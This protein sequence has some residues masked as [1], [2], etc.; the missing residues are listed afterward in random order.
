MPACTTQVED[1]NAYVY[2]GQIH[3]PNQ[4][5]AGITGS[6]MLVTLRD[7]GKIIGT[8][9]PSCD[10]VFVPAR[11]VCHECFEQIKKFVPVSSMGTVETFTVC[12]EEHI[13]QPVGRPIYAVIKLDEA[14]TSLVHM[15]GELEPEDLSIG[16][17][18]QA[19]FKDKK[20]RKASILDIRYF[21]PL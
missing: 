16:M 13:A 17:R 20:D 14:D 3:I 5:S 11:S 9:C 12:N 6:K 8:K 4:Y 7:K 15:L 19:V 18:V 10:T 2:D 1:S 21:K